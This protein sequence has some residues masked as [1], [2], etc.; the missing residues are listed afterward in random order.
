M[1]HKTNQ[2]VDYVILPPWAKGS[3]EMFTKTMRNA[4]E[5][6]YV[7]RNLN[8]WID[9]IF[10]YNRLVKKLKKHIMYFIIYISR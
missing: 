9:L 4:F 7:S 6:E 2:K 1:L 3:Y 10:G 5:S 8:Y